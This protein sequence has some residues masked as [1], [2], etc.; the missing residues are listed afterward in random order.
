MFE[1]LHSMSA[2][3]MY[4]ACDSRL[5]T[6]SRQDTEYTFLCCAILQSDLSCTTS[7]TKPQ[8]DIEKSIRVRPVCHDVD[9]QKFP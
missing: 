9:V 2:M 8:D 7:I 4:E 6:C 1:M 3:D 5:Y